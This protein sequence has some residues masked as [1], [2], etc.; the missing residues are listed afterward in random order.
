MVCWWIHSLEYRR[1]TPGKFGCMIAD[2]TKDMMRAVHVPLFFLLHC[3]S[4]KLIHFIC[5]FVSLFVEF[6]F[7]PF[8]NWAQGGLQYS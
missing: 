8:S 1:N 3:R 4:I 5:L 7:H 2:I 6:I